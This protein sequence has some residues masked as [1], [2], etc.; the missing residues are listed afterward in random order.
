MNRQ[1]TLAI[2]CIAFMCSVLVLVIIYVSW[3]HPQQIC[4]EVC[5]EDYQFKRTYSTLKCENR[6]A[7]IDFDLV[8]DIDEDGFKSGYKRIEDNY[9]R[10]R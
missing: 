6:T 7:V 10:S 3:I 2:I 1:Y 5:G 8:D 9:C 4:M